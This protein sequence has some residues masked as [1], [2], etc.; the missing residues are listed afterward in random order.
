MAI[1]ISESWRRNGGGSKAA[2]AA[3][4]KLEKW[5]QARRA[6]GEKRRSAALARR[7]GENNGEKSIAARGLKAAIAESISGSGISLKYGAK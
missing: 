1:S 2:N 4:A 7:V 5:H 3:A 6:G